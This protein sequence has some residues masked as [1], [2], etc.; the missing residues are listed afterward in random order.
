MGGYGLEPSLR[1]VCIRGFRSMRRRVF[2]LVLLAPVFWPAS[3]QSLDQ[4]EKF[5]ALGAGMN[6]CGQ[7]TKARVESG[8]SIA[9]ENWIQGFISSHNH[10]APGPNDLG[11]GMKLDA[12][13]SWVDNYCSQHPADLLVFAAEALVIEL[14][15][16]RPP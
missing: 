6:S 1:R 4:N 3:G 12:L 13:R 9:D 5:L 8:V 10:Y 7:W 15:K 2:A 16:R 14:I 11:M